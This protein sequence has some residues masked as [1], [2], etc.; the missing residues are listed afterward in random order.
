M[1]KKVRKAV[2][3]AAGLGTRF[4]PATKAIP[5]EMLA[6]VDKPIIQY[7]VE[8]A[9]AAGVEQI[10]IV[11]G[12]GKS[13]IEDHFDVSFEL[14]ATLERRGKKELLAVT[15]N[16]SNLVEL[17]YV[18]QKEA[19]GLGHAV[20]MAR[21][22]VGD[23]PFAVILPDDVI[24]APVPCLKQMIDVFDEL[25][26]SVLATQIVEGPAISAYGVL[27]G[28]PAKN[29]RVMNV[30]GMVEKPKPPD[31]PSKNAIIGRY[32]LT[33]KIFELLE[34]TPLGAGGELQLTDGIKTLLETEKV[35][36]Y[37]FDGIRHDAGDK[38]GMLKATVDFALK[39]ED[40]G[41]QFREYLKSLV[42]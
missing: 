18:R 10:I 21:D 16:V 9:L 33:P 12:R 36:G 30:K 17:A 37:T 11:T 3:P 42:L 29:P 23:E 35:Y 14:E 38:F 5:K 4:L 19:R 20:L 31:A 1:N 22:L 25:Q 15:R 8:E 28:T 6:L 34:R 7:G 41:P 24:D 26:G 13:A 39:R 32:I 2:F 40:M 27:D